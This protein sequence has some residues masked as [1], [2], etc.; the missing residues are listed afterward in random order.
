MLL[1][2]L[3]GANNSLAQCE[4]LVTAREERA[5]GLGWNTDTTELQGTRLQKLELPQPWEMHSSS[6]GPQGKE[7]KGK[8]KEH[9]AELTLSFK[10]FFG[11]ILYACYSLF[12]FF[13]NRSL[14]SK[15]QSLKGF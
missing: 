13:C 1:H 12:F 4:Q 11:Q 8:T 2:L 6:S 14:V 10:P 9:R 3:L 7:D 5:Q 15:V